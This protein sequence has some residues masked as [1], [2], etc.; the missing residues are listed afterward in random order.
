MYPC[1]VCK[2]RHC[3]RYYGTDF[4][5]V[6]TKAASIARAKAYSVSI[7][8][9]FTTRIPSTFV[10]RFGYPDVSLGVVHPIA[11]TNISYMPNTIVRKNNIPM[12]Q[13]I[14]SR[15]GMLSLQR[16]SNVRR[17]DNNS[18]V[19]QHAALSA[20]P[21]MLDVSLLSK[22]KFSFSIEPNTPP[23]GGRAV[24]GSVK[25]S[26]NISIDKVAG[27]VYYDTDLKSVD[28]IRLL[29]GRFDEQ[30]ISE[31]LSAGTMGVG[32]NRRLV[33]TR[34]SITA[35]DDI[36]GKQYI[37]S[38]RNHDVIES[39]LLFTGSF[40]GNYYYIMLLPYAYSYEL[41]ECYMPSNSIM[42]DCEIGSHRT[43][44]AYDTA[45]GYY[46]ARL[47]IL[48]YLNTNNMQS[49]ILALRLI[50][51][52]YNTPLGVWVVREAVRKTINSS[53]ICFDN[54]KTM[55]KYVIAHAMKHHSFDIANMINDSV[56]LD[57][58]GRQRTL[59]EYG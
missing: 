58:M 17:I 3:K 36:I 13:V 23:F 29:S 49:S 11:P 20:R 47:G 39:P 54:N 22:P 14:D 42:H 40:Y 52:E 15:M 19:V 8:N 35:T 43:G 44:Y 37:G 48:E 46:A 56:V 51:K 10:S 1:T 59:R 21:A 38:I 55:L 31:M 7:P 33:P 9:D 34:W 41:F 5:P 25:E 57:I 24:L 53:P 16:K 18:I 28:A 4:C 50:G 27:K 45:G 32:V 6:R 30:K 2:G 26:A 12:E